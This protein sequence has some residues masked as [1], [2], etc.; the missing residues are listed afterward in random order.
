M[1]KEDFLDIVNILDLTFYPMS[2]Y[3]EKWPF[4]LKIILLQVQTAMK[5]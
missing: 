1:A 3:C 2:I 4:S 5:L